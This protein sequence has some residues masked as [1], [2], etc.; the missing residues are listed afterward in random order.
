MK[1]EELLVNETNIEL[2]L[3]GNEAIARGAL[4]A[5]VMAATTYPGTP[6]SEVGDVLSG[7]SRKAGMYFEF[8][9][10]EKVAF[11]V[12]YASAISGLRSFVFMKHVGLNVASDPFMSSAYT[13]I[14][15]GLVVM[16][17]DDPSMFSSQNEQDNRHYGELAHVP[18]V[19]PSNPQEAKDFLIKA[20]EISELERIPVLFRT[21]TRVSHMREAVKLG[22]VKKELFASF[23]EPDSG[24]YMTLPSSAYGNKEK[25]IE[26]MKRLSP[27]SDKSDMNRIE[28]YGTGE[29]GF[30]TSGAA[31]N[32]LMDVINMRKLD[33]TVLKLGF[34]Y[35]F[36]ENLVADFMK[37]HSKIIIVEELDPILEARTRM[38]AQIKKIDS[39]IYGKL[40]GYFS[41]SHEYSPDTVEK[42]LSEIL[43]FNI[44]QHYANVMIE[45]PAPRPPVLC[46]G[47]PHRATFYAVKRAVRMLNLKNVIYSSDIGCYSLGTYEPFN[48][49]DLI[50][51]MGS[52][53]GA[54][55]GFASATSQPIIAFI[56]DSTFFHAGIPA[57]INAVHNGWK[58]GTNTFLW[59]YSKIFGLKTIGADR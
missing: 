29:I 8:S 51:S 18:V 26:K 12:A 57:L 22:P 44:T 2:F 48:E 42:S 55:S 19:E 56:G 21:T 46:P 3:L 10:N 6:S 40:D 7:I 32:S 27:V 16:T 58:D 41:M 25:L 35:P 4:E 39:E 30:I 47:C 50:I 13:G 14:K 20:F 38:V 31:Y 53:I 59:T 33:A 49:G 37:Q 15:A 1:I 24:R 52:S 43:G 34:T 54:A 36:P 45:E 9:T 28:R 5:G 23:F 11:E 17:A